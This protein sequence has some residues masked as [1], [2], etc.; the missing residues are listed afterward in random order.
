MLHLSLRQD[1]EKLERVQEYGK[2]PLSRRL[3]QDP[4]YLVYH[5]QG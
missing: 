3:R 5:R 2:L 4:V 1:V